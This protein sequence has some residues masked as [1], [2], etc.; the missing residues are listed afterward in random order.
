VFDEQSDPII[1]FLRESG[2]G[3]KEC[4]R[5]HRC[6]R[7]SEARAVAF[8]TRSGEH[9]DCPSVKKRWTRVERQLPAKS[10]GR[11]SEA[12]SFQS[13]GER[14][15]DKDLRIGTGSECSKNKVQVP[16]PERQRAGTVANGRAVWSVRRAASGLGMRRST[17]PTDL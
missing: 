5:Q 15:S 3:R 2:W 10:K 13:A 14:C 6:S 4:C 8:N 16:A 9:V 17:L 1:V 12:N 11:S 7:E